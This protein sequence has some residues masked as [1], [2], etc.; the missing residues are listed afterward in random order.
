M[1]TK[2]YRPDIHDFIPKLRRGHGTTHSLARV[3]D[4]VQL[5]AGNPCVNSSCSLLR[6][7]D[8]SGEK[9]VKGEAHL[10]PAKNAQEWREERGYG[11]DTP[12]EFCR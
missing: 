12:L 2:H 5:R 8:P 4:G 7:Q 3:R 1:T 10:D 9:K 11:K 6:R